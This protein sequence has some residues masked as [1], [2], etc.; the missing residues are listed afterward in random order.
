MNLITRHGKSSPRSLVGRFLPP[1]VNLSL[2]SHYYAV[3]D[4]WHS[5]AAPGLNKRRPTPEDKK[6]DAYDE[7]DYKKDPGVK[8]DREEEDKKTEK[9]EPEREDAAARWSHV[10][11][12]E[13]RGG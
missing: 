11:Q 1:V 9:E 8:E 5:G 3:R 10:C 12:F 2:K 4:K 6:H 13:K 7:E